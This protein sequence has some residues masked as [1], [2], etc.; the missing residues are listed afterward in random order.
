MPSHQR[1]IGLDIGSNTVSCVLVEKK[2]D[3]YVVLKDRSIATR[4]CESL[5]TEGKLKPAAIMRTL[6]AIEK[7]ADEFDMAY[8]PF[9]VV[10]TEA[11]RIAA[12]REDFTSQASEILGAGVEV[13]DS[14]TEA[15]LTV[16]GATMDFD[17]NS[18]WIVVDI[19]GRSTEICWHSDELSE[20]WETTSIPMGVV[21]LTS[22]FLLSDPPDPS[23]FESLKQYVH[24]Q[25]SAHVPKELTGEVVSVAGTATTLGSIDLGLTG[26]QRE[27][28]HCT[29][30]HKE[31]LSYW[32]GI[33][34]RITTEERV[35]KYEVH[36]GRADVFPSGLCTL[37]AVL[38]HLNRDSFIVSA[39]GLRVGVALSL[40]ENR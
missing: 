40:L 10:A 2:G 39:S 9:R 23:E 31:R 21:S 20:V 35:K 7:I 5:E 16:S 14:K 27:K 11:L 12:N 18:K 32:L 19:G 6:L 34:S 1:A 3:S 30:I 13:I 4:I 25:L 8:T 24:K 29:R 37:Q 17:K 28:V 15:L 36:R 22:E 26:W 38:E 33:M